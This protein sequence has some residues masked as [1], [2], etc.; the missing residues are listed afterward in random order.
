MNIVAPSKSNLSRFSNTLWLTIG[1]FVILTAV[2]FLYVRAEKKIDRAN[3]LRQQ[4]FM[5][6]QELRQSSDDLTRMVRTYVATGDP[7]YKRHFQEILDIRDGKKPRPVNYQNIYWDTVLLNDQRPRPPGSAISLL[8]LMRQAGFAEEEFAKLSEAKANSDALTRTEFAAMALVESTNP[9]SEANRAK[10]IQMLHDAAYHQAKARIMQPISEFNLMADQRTLK[11][12]HDAESF[13]T[14]IRLA[15]ILFGLSLIFLLWRTRRNLHAIL[16]GSVNELHARIARLGSGDF[17]AVIPVSTGMENSVLSWLS[18]TQINLARID[19]QRKNAETRNQRLT[20]LYAAL[21]HCNQAIVRCTNEAELFGSICRDIVSFGGLKMAWIG[22]IDEQN[23]LIRP[24]ASAGSGTEYLKELKISTDSTSHLGPTSRACCENQPFWIQDF[25]HDPSTAVWHEIGAKFG[26]AASAALPVH[27]NGVVL[28]AF[29]L[30]ADV[31]DAFDEDVRNLLVEIVTDID[32]ALK[33]FMNE[34]Q[35][36]QAEMDLR[37]AAA[38]FESQE[39]MLVTDAKNVILRVNRAFT[40]STGYSAEE[41]IGRTPRL[42]QSGRHNADFYSEMWKIINR[43]GGWQ[44]EVWD[45]RK[46]GEEYQKWLTISAVKDENG[47]VTNYIGTH[48]DIT[49]RKNAEEKIRRLAFFDP[50]T[51]LPNR[52][53]LLDRLK[54]AMSVG[55]RSGNY[56]ALLLIDLD[57]FKTLNDTLGH[58]MGDMLL[59]QVAQRLNTSVRE[60]DTVARLGGDEF[61]VMLTNLGTIEADAAAQVETEAQKL[62]FTFN[63]T[64]QLKDIAHHVTPSIGATL[65]RGHLT[66]IDD[67]LKQVDLAMYKSKAAGRNMLHFFDPAMEAAALERV[68]LEADL[69]VALEQHQFMLYY[70]PQLDLRIGQLVG[71]EALVRWQHPKRGIVS[72][73][74]FIPIAEETGLIIPIGDWVLQEACRQLGEWRASGIKHIKMSVNLAAKQF[75]DQNLPARIQE[76]IVK[77][78]LPP[79]SLEL[80]VTESMTMGSPADAIE[81]MKVLTSQGQSMSIDDFGTGYSS[82]AYLKLFPISTLKIDRAF[83]KDIET[84]P[85]DAA[86]CDITVLLAH[87]LGM[88]V[89]AE[90]VETEGQLKFLNSIGCEK[91]QGYLISKPLPAEQAENF[92]RTHPR[93]TSLGTVELW[94]MQ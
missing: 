25:Q 34:A 6:A 59:K 47:A 82:L 67:L 24:V 60:G 52:T 87:K 88:K 2:F 9:P 30:Y 92:I 48:Y 12:V 49:E 75:S 61:V 56:G 7:I 81:M 38:A 79:E 66:V 39:A 5:L 89:V 71:V 54:Q 14:L 63:Q 80:E 21:S 40:E 76:V 74:E 33:I 18:E 10:A 62:L 45:Q 29:S 68:S 46:N 19:A 3:E 43:T 1:I 4:S 36:K 44:G 32:Y 91:I 37:I 41:A 20:Q 83:V 85:N 69:R 86:I 78:A 65:F 77:Y 55:A 57:N 16:G 50:L 93:I 13:A 31:T 17:S 73:L 90:G 51:G 72:P 42:I 26:W 23:K 58:D 15:L 84:D 22:V 11:A 8:E 53:L 28:G 94:A 27:R 64:Y 70:Q 35:R